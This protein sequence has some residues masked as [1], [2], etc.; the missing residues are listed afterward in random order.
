MPPTPAPESGEHQPPARRTRTAEIIDAGT[1]AIDRVGRLSPQQ[2]QTAVMIAMTLFV[3]GTCGYLIY[4]AERSKNEV[5]GMMLRSVE[6]EGER[7]RLSQEARHDKMIQMQRE[8]FARNRDL[9]AV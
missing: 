3:C 7:N 2:A 8:E 6:S 5:V 1:G 9:F 4:A